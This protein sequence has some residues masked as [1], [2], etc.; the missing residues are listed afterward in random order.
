M[1]NI[2]V[3]PSGTD[4]NTGLEESAPLQ[5][6]QAALNMAQEGDTISLAEGDYEENVKVQVPGLLWVSTAPVKHD[7]RIRLMDVVAPRNRFLGLAFGTPNSQSF[8]VRLNRG[9]HETKLED[10]LF[11]AHDVEICRPLEFRVPSTKPFG[12]DAASRCVISGCTFTRGRMIAMLDLF[13]DDNK[14]T[15][16]LFHTSANVDWIRCHGRRH[17]IQ[18]CHFHGSYQ[19]PG[20]NHPDFFQCFSDPQKDGMGWGSY[21]HVVERNM[22][23]DCPNMQLTQMSN[24]GRLPRDQHGNITFRN[25]RFHGIGLQASCTIP[26]VRY[27]SNTF[28]QCN[29]VNEG[30]VLSFG[31]R[32]YE[33]RGVQSGYIIPGD[34]YRVVSDS[35]E[36]MVSYNGEAMNRRTQFYGVPGVSDFEVTGDARVVEYPLTFAHGA[37]IVGNIFLHCG[38]P[39]RGTSGWYALDPELKDVV[40]DFNYVGKEGPDGSEYLPVKA[41]DKPPGSP[42]WG[43][44]DSYRFYED[45]GVN[46]GDPGID[47]ASLS[48]LRP[49]SMLVA[50][51]PA[52]PLALDDCLTAIRAN[53]TAIGAHDP[54]G[55]EPGPV[56]PPPVDDPIDLVVVT[57]VRKS[58]AAESET[59][60]PPFTLEVK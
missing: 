35:G 2:Y 28:V 60:R 55:E 36:G 8:L 25:N 59:H 52:H 30:P 18:D 23:W 47:H 39:K 38:S 57:K 27:I 24:M 12:E 51:M 7:S 33:G 11:D 40:C 3:S 21:G 17:V 19:V 49:D 48:T 14:V 32:G 13:G 29:T 58:G 34:S 56:E 9:A 45:H 31:K 41:G 50:R 37:T 10:C 20:G 22:V 44:D 43:V 16:C 15:D 53:P 5:T 42:G 6:I 46:G 1:K 54:L 4:A 26:D